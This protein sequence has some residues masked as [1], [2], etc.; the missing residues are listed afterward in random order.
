MSTPNGV[1]CAHFF[2]IGTRTRTKSSS[3]HPNQKN[4]CTER[5]EVCSFFLQL[6]SGL[7]PESSSSH[8]N[9]KIRRFLSAFFCFATIY[10][11]SSGRNR[12]SVSVFC[13]FFGKL[14]NKTVN[15]GAAF[16]LVPCDSVRRKT[17]FLWQRKR[18][19]FQCGIVEYF[20]I[21]KN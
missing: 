19:R 2:A 7:E 11:I 3:S 10:E 5:S 12:R 1:R 18:H 17:D 21:R 4:E 8:P 20:N 16:P 13:E 14:M 15:F 6:G 9:R